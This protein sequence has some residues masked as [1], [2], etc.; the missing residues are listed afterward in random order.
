MQLNVTFQSF[1]IYSVE[2][3]HEVETGSRCL[4]PLYIYNKHGI[5]KGSNTCTMTTIPESHIF[6]L[7]PYSNSMDYGELVV[8]CRRNILTTSSVYH[9]LYIM[10]TCPC[11]VDPLKPHFY[12]VIMGFKGVYIIFSLRR[13]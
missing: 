6:K 2:Q 1:T 9:F 10:L 12:I 5:N 4:V 11:N 8:M 13:F 3:V 7:E